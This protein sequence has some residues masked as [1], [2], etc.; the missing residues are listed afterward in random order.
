MEEQRRHSGLGIA[1][2]ITGTAAMVLMFLLLV[3]AGALEASTPGGM[4][5]QSAAAV[6]VGSFLILFI[7]TSVVALGLG[8]AGLF[9]RER[10]KVFPILGTVFSSFTVLGTI[11]V[12]M[13]GLAMG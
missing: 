12:V 10:R 2:F 13:V 9:Q 1:S 8:I 6:I 3:V 11:F 7:L 4:D 5:E